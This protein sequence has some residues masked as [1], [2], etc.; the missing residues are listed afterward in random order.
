MGWMEA[1]SSAGERD[2]VAWCEA[3]SGKCRTSAR[4]GG[5]AEKTH[6]KLLLRFE[7]NLEYIR[8]GNDLDE[9]LNGSHRS[10]L[11]VEVD[12]PAAAVAC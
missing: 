5:M 2:D 12:S 3:G 4:N 7:R 9:E 8:E 10:I 11:E 6:R 1:A